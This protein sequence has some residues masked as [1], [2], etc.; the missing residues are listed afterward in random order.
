MLKKFKKYR[1]L[2]LAI[3]SSLMVLLFFYKTTST[4]YSSSLSS[5]TKHFDELEGDLD[6]T[7]VY[8][9]DEL[10]HGVISKQWKETGFSDNI[11]VHVYRKDSLIFWNTNQLP[12]H[13]FA[14]I[15]F[16]SSGLLHLQNGWYFAKKKKVGSYIICASFLV[17]RDYSY[18]NSELINHWGSGFPVPFNAE[19]SLDQS[20]GLPVLSIDNSFV[21]SVFPK[22]QQH[23]SKAE[24]IWLMLLLLVSLLLWFFWLSQII[25]KTVPKLSPLTLVMVV[26]LRVFSLQF[27]WFAFTKGS[28]A[29]EANLYG[30]NQWFPNLFEYFV[31]LIIIIFLMHQIIII[32]RR[33]PV[34]I[35]KK[36]TTILLLFTSFLLWFLY[37]FLAYGLIENSTISLEIDKLFSL[38]AFSFLSI[39][40]LGVFFFAYYHFVRAL[41]ELCELQGFSGSRLA[42][43]CF[44][45]GC[46]C[47]LYEIS[48]GHQLLLASLFPLVFYSLI[49]FIVYRKEKENKLGPGIVLLLLF[50]VVTAS[51]IDEFN[52][53]KEKGERE[54]YAHQLIT[55]K[56]I[57]TELEYKNI[58][59]DLQKDHFLRKFIDN[60]VAMSSSSFQEGIERR[61]FNGYWERYEI[62]FH[63]FDATHLPLIDKLKANT[64]QYDALNGIIERAGTLSELDSNIFFID[65]YT[66]QYNYIIRQEILSKNGIKGVL[67]CTLKSKKIP[68][69][70]GFPRLLISSKSNVLKPLEAYSIARY[71]NS[72]MIT[73]YG[74]FNY[75]SSPDVFGKKILIQKGFFN[76]NKFNHFSLKK[77]DSDIVVLSVRNKTFIDFITSFSYLFSLYGMLLMPLLFRINAKNTFSRT[78]SLAMKIQVVLI[79]LVFISLLAFGWGSGMFV[80]S[81]YNHLT[82]DVISEKLSSVETEVGVK[83]GSFDNLTISEN[84]NYMQYI[85]QKFARVF[86][87]DINLYD[88]QGYLL[89]SSRPK[90]Y[91]IGLLSEQMNPT[92]MRHLKYLKESEFVHKENIGELEYSSAYKPFYSTK[93]KLLGYINLQHFGQQ[94]E[95]ENQIQKFLV[96]IINVFILLL[97][98]S[99]ILTI[100]I[101]N[102]LTSPLRL[103]QENFSKVKFGKQN[104]QILYDKEDEIGS[105][106]KDYNRKLEEL[107]FTAQQLAK[108]ERE[109]AWREMAKQVAHEIKNPLTPMK[110]SVQQL[111]R[112]Y[113][114]EDPT[115]GDKLKKVA[116]SII[117]QIDALTKIANEFSTFA[118]M[119][120]PSEEKLDIVAL[121]EGVKGLF[122]HDER[123]QISLITNK[124]EINV[125]ADK[126]QFVRVF[127][128]LIKNAT[129]AIPRDQNG[130]IDIR[131][132]AA[133][134][135]VEISITDNG[136]GIE[137][138]RQEKIFV[139][140]FTTK[141]TGTGLGLAMVK[142]IIE[143]HK[144][145]ID[146]TSTLGRGTTFNIILPTEKG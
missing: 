95:F 30:S 7:I 24:S 11:N 80:T 139:P 102:W 108:S 93:G 90:V 27:E 117:E 37:L 145:K 36:Y 55:E 105:L 77:S 56:N 84:G 61:I 43:V 126:D 17:K 103:L 135:Y 112:T 136:I 99:I 115:S 60:P 97:A 35:L 79:T 101:S 88:R 19:I 73:K 123:V 8:R 144:G 20:I 15:H 125:L 47:F 2:F 120:N 109:T 62:S 21:F 32:L 28:I 31:N 128:N 130:S 23:L 46:F 13:R 16:P 92:A 133:E 132:K 66:K 86:F 83:L 44:S 45:L 22:E 78:L 143:N 74:K 67:F 52:E 40:S 81:Q 140:Y 14:D 100:F 18:K 58:S 89:A 65:D 12:I 71:H 59:E 57:E 6:K 49:L 69:E 96:A 10:K 141:S 33:V 127:N 3:F 9:S 82:N 42:V 146:F 50:S 107:E 70:I 5:L 131:L 134:N 137:E 94:R 4:E 91:N 48:W 119:P 68:E 114:P 34:G 142:Q 122:T 76:Y 124:P 75:P 104:E 51:T 53:R 121:I 138:T 113:N 63:L 129:Q 106:V 38:D 87:T 111:L 98:I 25:H 85:L 110:L 116:G 26:V 72:R 41:M 29:F 39:G 64:T 1:N 118:K 54:L